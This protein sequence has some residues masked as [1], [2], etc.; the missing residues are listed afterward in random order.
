M[1]VFPLLWIIMFSFPSSIYPSIHPLDFISAFQSYSLMVFPQARSLYMILS[2]F[3]VQS[4]LPS[5][6]AAWTHWYDQLNTV[7]LTIDWAI[8]IQMPFERIQ[9]I[10]AFFL[11]RK[12]WWRDA[13]C[14]NNKRNQL[15][16][17]VTVRSEGRMFI[18]SIWAL[19]YCNIWHVVWEMVDLF[20]WKWSPSRKRNKD[21]LRVWIWNSWEIWNTSF[22]VEQVLFSL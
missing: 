4:L 17:L 6:P 20:R 14:T 21:D 13:S 18:Y 9:L 22:N 16:G 2:F 1:V 11:S 3:L 19:C 7:C 15:A 5:F 8:F 12:Q 10:W